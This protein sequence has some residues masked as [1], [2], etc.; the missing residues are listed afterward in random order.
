MNEETKKILLG[1]FNKYPLI[2]FKKGDLIYRPG[3]EFNGVVFVKSGYVRVYTISNNKRQGS[4]KM[5]KPLFYLSVISQITGEKNKYFMEAITPVELWVSPKEEFMTFCK[6]NSFV[7]NEIMK[8]M[9]NLLL[10]L[11]DYTGKLLFGN[12][13]GKVATIITSVND[14]KYKVNLTHKIIGSL[15]G[16][17][18]ETVTLQLLKLKK[19]KLIEIKSKKMTIIDRKGLEKL[20]NE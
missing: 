19:M 5:F 9:S 17:T 8:T 15:T 11:I 10:D 20:I 3:D 14:S 18:R 2:K 7:A 6:V 16:L 13:L 12:S 4:I 1:F